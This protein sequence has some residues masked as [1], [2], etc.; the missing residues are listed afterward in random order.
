MAD[1]KME[2]FEVTIAQ[3]GTE[4]TVINKSNFSI[5]GFEVPASMTS[6]ALTFKVGAASDATVPL[7]GSD[8]SAISYTIDNTAGAYYMPAQYTAGYPYFRI[9]AG[10]SEAAARTIKIYGYK[11]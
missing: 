3:D 6:T 8:N 9:V 2:I 11:A 5:M 1:S 7:R 10:S 4:S